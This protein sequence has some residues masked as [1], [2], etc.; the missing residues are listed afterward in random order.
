[1]M[2]TAA[3][4]A[5][6]MML[7]A[8][9]ALVG[10]GDEADAVDGDTE[11][12]YVYS[13]T[14]HMTY[15]YDTDGLTVAWDIMDEDGESIRHVDHAVEWDFDATGHDVITVR[16]TV[17]DSNGDTDEKT[18]VVHVVPRNDN[19][20]YITFMDRGAIYY[21]ERIDS[22]R[23]IKVGT[24]FVILPEDE[25]TRNGFS[26]DGWYLDPACTQRLDVM[27]PVTDHLTVYAGWMPIGGSS[28]VVE[29]DN[30]YLVTFNV[31][32]GLGYHAE[33]S[34]SND[35][36][37]T[38][39]V[40]DGYELV[41]DIDVTVS[42]GTLMDN[43][44]DS[45]VLTDIESNILVTISGETRALEPSASDDG[46]FPWWIVVLVIVVIVIAV[47]AFLYYRKRQE[48]D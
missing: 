32:P 11:T 45:Y 36:S 17:S 31:G 10:V 15:P 4:L 14:V 47:T 33:V 8:G 19:P 20:I 29:I 12:W 26:F 46:G 43:G 18:I 23:A 22:T 38:V 1:M 40:Q 44:G 37:F 25:P 2:K 5:A 35:L 48:R 13:S 27:E 34:N 42:S 24:P 39:T 16:Q 7:V 41:G 28:S 6:L 9:A 3:V 30:V 21:T